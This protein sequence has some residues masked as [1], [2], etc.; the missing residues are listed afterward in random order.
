MIGHYTFDEI[1]FSP[2][3][4]AL[5]GKWSLG[6]H[7]K[8]KP[9]AQNSTSRKTQA[10]TQIPFREELFLPSRPVYAIWYFKKEMLFLDD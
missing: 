4:F 7:F 2:P 6:Q 1:Y 8:S 9:D 3:A 10:T 5:M